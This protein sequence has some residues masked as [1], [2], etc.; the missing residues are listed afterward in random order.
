MKPGEN[1]KINIIVTGGGTGGHLFPGI[2]AAEGLRERLP[3][4]NIMFIGTRRHLDK[5]TLSRYPYTIATISCRGLK[6][7]GLPARLTALL[8]LPPAVVSAVGHIRSHRSVLVFG[9]GG[10]VTGP[11]LLAAKLLGI[12]TCIHEQNAVPGMANRMLSRFV[13]RIFISIPVEENIFPSKKTV[14]TGNP[15]RREIIAAAAK[16][17]PDKGE[18]QTLLVLGGSQGAHSINMLMIKAAG[19]IKNNLRS[20]FFILHQ[21]G[22]KDLEQVRR[23]YRE[24]GIKARVEEFFHDMAAAYSQADL[25]VSRAGATTLAELSVMGLPALLIPYPYAAD[26]HQ[27]KNAGYYTEGGGAML[28]KQSDLTG[29]I[30]ATNIIACLKNPDKL[31]TMSDCM[32]ELGRP[33]ATKVLVDN[34]L[35]LIKI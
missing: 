21:S 3:G 34:L 17:R 15:V 2:A 29:K 35:E 32:K 11:V 23:C 33:E 14:L 26:N 24:M 5:S 25:V 8:Q 12:P 20:P 16:P 28:L 22:G 6:G 31:H 1:D 27:E 13:D 10:Y 19:M 30:L 4:C 9:V 18:K 7:K